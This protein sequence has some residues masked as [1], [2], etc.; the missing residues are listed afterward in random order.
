[1]ISIATMIRSQVSASPGS[2]VS[3][4]L[5]MQKMMWTMR[6]TSSNRFASKS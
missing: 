5:C 4:Q 3:P 2:T 6:R 1:M